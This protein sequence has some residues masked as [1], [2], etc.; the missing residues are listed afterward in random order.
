MERSITDDETERSA[1]KTYWT[2]HSH[3]PSIE[4]M[5]LDTQ[6]MV[7]DAADRP[8]VRN[9]RC[10][11]V[12]PDRTSYCCF[13]I[14]EALGSVEG[15]TV[16]ELGAG[17]GRLTRELAKT[18]AKVIACDFLEN[19]TRE[20]EKRNG[21]MANIDFITADAT[22]LEL[23]KGSI[24]VV[25][26]NWLLMYLSDQEIERFVKRALE[27]VSLFVDSTSVPLPFLFWC[28]VERGG[29]LLFSRVLLSFIGRYE[30]K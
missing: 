1:Q 29:Y 15:K 12:F 30:K 16:L 27:W 23:P 8:E 14:L 25:F 10:L 6:A 2:D 22:K 28:A 21:T 19:L 4:T 18:A 20:N 5:M 3:N 11:S 17:M 9:E 7:L 26:S 24:D 13:Q